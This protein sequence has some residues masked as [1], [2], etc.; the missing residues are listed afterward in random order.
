MAQTTVA[1]TTIIHTKQ[2][3]WEGLLE[4]VQQRATTADDEMTLELLRAYL[5]FVAE[6]YPTSEYFRHLAR[7]LG[8]HQQMSQAEI[9]DAECAEPESAKNVEVEEPEFP[10]REEWELEKLYRGPVKPIILGGEG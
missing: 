3:G 8:L 2:T 10:S 1:I 6:T 5:D 9:V 4:R 7:L